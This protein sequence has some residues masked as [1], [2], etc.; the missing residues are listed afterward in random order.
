YQRFLSQILLKIDALKEKLPYL[1]VQN[2]IELCQALLK[3]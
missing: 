2:E 1:D 3:K